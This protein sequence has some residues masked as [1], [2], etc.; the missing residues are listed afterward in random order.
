MCMY[1]GWT[2]HECFYYY[3]WITS[4]WHTAAAAAAIKAKLAAKYKITNLDAA[5]QFLG[6]QI[7]NDDDGSKRRS[8]TDE[9]QC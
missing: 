7:T 6:I 9:Y 2:T 3:M 4:P 5:K 1:T 8:Y